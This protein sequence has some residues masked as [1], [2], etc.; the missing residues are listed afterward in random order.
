MGIKTT[1]YRSMSPP[2][3]RSYAY[4]SPNNPDINNRLET[5]YGGSHG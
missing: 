3:S 5:K 1:L 4:P 2:N